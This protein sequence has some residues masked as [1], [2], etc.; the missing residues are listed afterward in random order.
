MTILSANQ[1]TLLTK[2]VKLGTLTEEDAAKFNQT[3]F[4]S[5]LARG[6]L[7][8]NRQEFVVTA[9]AI[10]ALHDFR[11]AD[12]FRRIESMKLHCRFY[13]DTGRKPLTQ[14]APKRVVARLHR[15]A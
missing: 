14:A 12:V 4:G 3:T 11:Q 2:F 10:E 8:W 7:L 1:Y 15:V 13:R 6:Y 5:F 9:E